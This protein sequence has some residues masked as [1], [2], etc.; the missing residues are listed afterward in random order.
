MKKSVLFFIL[1]LLTACSQTDKSFEN[2][3]GGAP[4]QT[5]K[6][7]F[8]KPDLQVGIDSGVTMAIIDKYCWED[9]NKTCNIE[10]DKPHDLLLGA[11]SLTVPAG[12]EIRFRINAKS[13]EELVLKDMDSVTMTQFFK[14]EESQIEVPVGEDGN[15]SFIA[16]N[17]KGRYFYSG[18]I[19]WDSEVKGEASFAFSIIVK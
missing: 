15:R 18:L 2:Q 8:G 9:E 14:S 16:P 4:I 17:E 3:P 6:Q 12:E 7:N 5:T 11:F 1:F 13:F 19:R 10:P